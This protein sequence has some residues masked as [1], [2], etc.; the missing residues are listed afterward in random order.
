MVGSRLLPFLFANICNSTDTA[1]DGEEE[2]SYA[3]ERLEESGK[4]L[5]AISSVNVRTGEV[6]M[7]YANREE[8]CR[9]CVMT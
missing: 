1:A 8:V 4:K 9:L 3:L 2:Y 5:W 6:S 7:L